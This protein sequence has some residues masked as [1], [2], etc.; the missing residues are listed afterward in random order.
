M[1]RTYA[2]ILGPLAMVTVVAR[3]LIHGGGVEVPLKCA[4]LCLVLFAIIGWI[5]GR[6][7]ERI[8]V[9]AARTRLMAELQTT[10]ATGQLAGDGESTI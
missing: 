8:V 4:C 10:A 1:G 9:E 5:A 2:G 3:A 6:W 7:A